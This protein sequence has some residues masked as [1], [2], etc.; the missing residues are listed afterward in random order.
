[1]SAQAPVR[2][3]LP[4]AA[5]VGGLLLLSGCAGGDGSPSSGPSSAGASSSE[6]AGQDQGSQAQSLSV[7]QPWLKAADSGMTAAFGQL[8]NDGDAPITLT[9]AAADGI[10]GEVELH[11]TATDPQTGSTRMQALEDPI[12]IEP[13]ET[14]E[15]EPGGNHIML[16]DLQC[17]PMAGTELSLQLQLDDGS[18]HSLE[19]PVRD[20]AAAQEEYAPGEEPTAGG[21][22]EDA[23][24]GMEG[25]EGMD[26]G[27]MEGMDESASSQ[28]LP[29]CE[30]AR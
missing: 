15:L 10:A 9:G 21:S 24:D 6:A 11:E 28:A 7:D 5:A 20:Y 25:M 22:S 26:H 2:R 17:A 30:A 13:G 12:V 14:V 27:G 8:R 3:L 18:E 1:M 16:M 4:A 23:A 19:L 29:M